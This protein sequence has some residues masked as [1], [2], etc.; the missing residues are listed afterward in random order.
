LVFSS[1]TFLFVFLP[2]TLLL[3]YAFGKKLRNIILL[4][5]SLLFYAWG[6]NFYVLLMLC[7]IGFNYFIGLALDKSEDKKHKTRILG[8]G[9]F[10]NLLSLG[11]FKYT[12]WLVD[13]IDGIFPQL[14]RTDLLT[15]PIH[16]PIG[17]SF[18]TFQAISYIIDVYRAETAPQKNPF[19][20]GLYIASFPQLIAGPIVRYNQVAQ[21]IITRKHSFAL[22]AEG[23]E[24][25]VYGLSKKVLLA[26]PLAAVGDKIFAMN[27]EQLSPELAWLGIICYTLQIFFDFSGYS[28]M[29]IGLG[30]MFGFKFPENFNYPYIARSIQ[31]FWQRWH[32][33]LSSW[34]RDYLYIPLGGNRHGEQKTYRNL[35]I[36]FILCGIWHGAS[37][38]FLIWGLI[39]GAFLVIERRFLHRYLKKIPVFLTHIYTMFIVINAWVFFRVE[40]LSDAIDYLKA[41]YFPGEF[42]TA[43]NLDLFNA[44]TSLFLWSLMA[45]VV[46]A[47]PAVKNT[48]QRLQISCTKIF[49][50]GGALGGSAKILTHCFLLYLCIS[51]LAVNSYNPFIYF[52]F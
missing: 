49:V 36:V 26:N 13:I 21:Q 17:I 46:F 16:L 15:D 50:T 10:A 9:I 32:I 30:K 8:F 14:E 44:T 3:Y 35:L 28:D 2:F 33:S 43:F 31:D 39:H 47:T 1:L 6:E 42:N 7:S 24:R 45:A 34:F 38:N 52:R 29:A 37:M 48:L 4:L 19:H 23:V 18:F 11:I 20:L 41:M 40:D 5:A 12:N 25:F 27:Y 51:F 22:F